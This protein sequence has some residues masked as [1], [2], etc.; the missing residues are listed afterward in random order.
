MIAVIGIWLGLTLSVT[1]L[2]TPFLK[3]VASQWSKP[4][5]ALIAALPLPLLM[6]GLGLM[7]LARDWNAATGARE[8]QTVGF[9]AGQLLIS[10][11]LVTL[12]LGFLISRFALSMFKRK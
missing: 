7:L 9:T 6:A 8:P 11:S 3:I 1:T 4:R 12:G 5:I 10:F 2:F